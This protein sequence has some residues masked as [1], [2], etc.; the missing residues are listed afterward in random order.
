[1]AAFSALKTIVEHTLGRT[2]DSRTSAG[3]IVNRAVRFVC[4]YHPWSWRLKTA[5]ISFAGK[6]ISSMSRTSD[7]VSATIAVPHGLAAGDQIRITGATPSTF[8]GTYVVSTAPLSTT[9][10]W[11]QDANNE[12]ATTTGTL[13]S[14]RIALPSDFGEI[15][16]LKANSLQWTHCRRL[17]FGE[18]LDERRQGLYDQYHINW[19]VAQTSRST[20]SAS[21]S[22]ALEVAPIQQSDVTNAATLT[23][24]RTVADLSGDTDVPDVPAEMQDA[25]EAAVRWMAW[26]SEAPTAPSTAHHFE[27]LRLFLDRAVEQDR[28]RQ[29]ATMGPILGSIRRSGLPPGWHESWGVPVSY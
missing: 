27:V 26:E 22:F 23:Y 11:A 6:S 3:D 2:V 28:R 13:Y 12:V 20:S 21:C 19:A 5:N 16:E 10:T 14:G 17:S 9:L 24:L 1:M 25:V 8:N 18:I 29:G 4:A 15:Q 7:V